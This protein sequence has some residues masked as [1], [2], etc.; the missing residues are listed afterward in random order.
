MGRVNLLIKS[1]RIYELGKGK[2]ARNK[3]A[4]RSRK[5]NNQNARRRGREKIGSLDFPGFV[6][7]NLG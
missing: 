2:K 3:I 4:L 6:T 5:F 1:D 7:Q